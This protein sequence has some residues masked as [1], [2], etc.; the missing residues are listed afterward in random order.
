MALG[1]LVFQLLG[2]G[3]RGRGPERTVTGHRVMAGRPR[4]KALG[5]ALC[6]E[7]NIHGLCFRQDTVQT[8]AAGEAVLGA[9]PVG[10]ESLVGGLAQPVMV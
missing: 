10:A 4:L 5:A 8:G 7:T 1:L 2:T 3:S 9:Q 6:P